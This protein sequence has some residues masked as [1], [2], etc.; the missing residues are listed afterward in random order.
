M[1]PD[2]PEVAEPEL[3]VSN[4]LVPLVPELAVAMESAPLDVAVPAP[5]RMVIAPPVPSAVPAPE[6][7]SILTLPP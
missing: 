7:A 2:E 3:K 1:V 6:P 5:V 4:P